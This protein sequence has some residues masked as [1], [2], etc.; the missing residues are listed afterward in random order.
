M[1][2]TVANDTTL[3]VTPETLPAIIW[4][5]QPVI[6]TELLA[7]VYGTV[8]D[9]IKKNFERNK[10]RFIEGVH[11]F[12]LKGA[13][14]KAFKNWVT[15]S[16]SVEN[17]QV[18][19]SHLQIG[20]RAASLYLWTERG[21]VRHAKIL[22]TDNAWAVQ[23]RLE[24]FYFTKNQPVPNALRDL[25][26]KTLNPAMLRHIEKRISWLNKN[27]VGSTYQS[28]GRMI[29]EK[30]NVNERKAIP[31]HKYAEV[32]ALLGCEPD[33][34]ALQGEL[35]ETPKLEYQPPAGMV[36]IAESEL[37]DLKKNPTSSW[38]NHATMILT[39]HKDA[40]YTVQYV[41]GVSVIAEQPQ[42]VMIGTPEN[43]I[44]DLKAHGYII[45]KNEKHALET[46]AE[47]ANSTLVA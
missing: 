39:S 38:N 28:L 13:D 29:K 25:P 34:K 41:N 33:V 43:I 12:L 40:L 42:N 2:N 26:P 19:N 44:H 47:I 22:E 4:Q 31:I 5:N 10:S 16:H 21:T 24:D 37:A 17:F 1:N 6:T 23:D 45:V 32:C 14:L 7:E 30:F 27:Q 9:N 36:L 8:T 11:Y 15:N 35:V 18:T 46:I 20:A 3:S